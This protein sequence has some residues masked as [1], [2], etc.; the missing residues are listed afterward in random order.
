M[1][2]LKA[3]DDQ[4]APIS[5]HGEFGVDGE[6][7]G[8]LNFDLERERQGSGQDVE[9]RAEVGRGGG[10][11]DQAPAPEGHQPSTARSTAPSSGSHGS[12]AGASSRAVWGSFNPWPVRMQATRRAPSAPYSSRPA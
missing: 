3:T 4:V 11:A 2:P 12:T 9:A 6:I 7:P 1:K 10:D 5:G 8:L